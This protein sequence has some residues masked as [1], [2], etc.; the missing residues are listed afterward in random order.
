MIVGLC[1]LQA[2]CTVDHRHYE[3]RYEVDEPTFAAPCEELCATVILP[4]GDEFVS[5]DSVRVSAGPFVFCTFTEPG[6][7]NF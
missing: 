7:S 2:A 6:E 3:M 4:E 5:C 1:I